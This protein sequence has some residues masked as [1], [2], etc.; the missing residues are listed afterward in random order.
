M[1]AV[2]AIGEFEPEQEQWT[3]YSERLGHYFTANGI[4]DEE[5]NK[6]VLLTVIGRVM[7]KLLRNLIAPETVDGI[8]YG[9]IVDG[10][11]RHYF[12]QL[13]EI[14]RRYEFNS[15]SR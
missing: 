2:R 8:S 3:Q 6:A 11:S 7:Y 14:V 12:P 13:S 5:K 10:L 15:R 1:A 4:T 9:E